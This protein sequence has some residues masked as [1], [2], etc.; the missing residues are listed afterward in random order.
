MKPL[1]KEEKAAQIHSFIA[2]SEPEAPFV[3]EWPAE[4]PAPGIYEVSFE[5]YRAWPAINASALKIGYQTSALHM[6]A[7]I[8]GVLNSDSRARK[9]GRAIHARLL[10]PDTFA[11]RFLIAGRCQELLKS[12]KRKGEPCGKWGRFHYDGSWFCGAHRHEAAV[13]PAEYVD[14]NEAEQIERI[15]KSVYSHSV[16]KM[17]SAHGGAEVSIIWNWDG[18]ACKARFDKWITKANCPD[19]I[20]DLK[21]CQVFKA[22]DHSLQSSIRTYGWDLQAAWYVD[23]AEKITGTKPLWAWVFLEDNEP[24]DTRPVWCSKALMEIGR[25][26]MQSAFDLYKCC[27]E[28]SQWPGYC[29]NIEELYPAEWEMK[30][31]GIQP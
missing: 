20:V 16:V 17:L 22:D 29:E 5:E 30:R 8:D 3:P 7:A 10:E 25:I 6:K 14:G 23:G 24:F 13:E 4:C 12:G 9:F 18:F 26:K 1:S 27:V 15:V 19:T 31:Y 11:E 2:P 28:V 21:K